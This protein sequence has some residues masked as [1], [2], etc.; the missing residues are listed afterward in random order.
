MP[1]NCSDQYNYIAICALL[2]IE[3]STKTKY[4]VVMLNINISRMKFSLKKCDII[5][6]SVINEKTLYYHVNTFTVSPSLPAKNIGDPIRMTV[7]CV[8]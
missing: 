4:I 3:K 5:L 8:I 6:N 1:D 7:H 2:M